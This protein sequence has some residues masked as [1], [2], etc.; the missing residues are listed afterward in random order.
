MFMPISF[1][2]RRFRPDEFDAYLGSIS[3]SDFQPEFVTL[4]H[5]GAPTL[6]S[7]PDGLTDQHLRNL[8]T[9]YQD[10]LGWNGAPHLFIDDRPDGII[11]FQMLDKRGVHAVSFNRNSWGVE[12]LGEY[13]SEEFNSGRGALVRDNAV[14]AISLLNKRINA[15]PESL[16]FHRDDPQTNKTCPGMRVQKADMVAR[17]ASAMNQS[18]PPDMVSSATPWKVFLS[19]GL[20]IRLVHMV[21]GRPTCRIKELL[22]LIRPGGSYALNASKTKVTWNTSTGNVKVINVAQI[23]EKGSP[24]GFLADIAAAARYK[25]QVNGKVITLTKI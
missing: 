14:R 8:L 4:H 25:V 11:V 5:T 23:D 16:K 15:S 17:I 19:T 18:P 21:G 3:F 20:E 13:D 9:Y 22:T 24:W 7:R 1:V 10:E 12:M 6:A 2:G